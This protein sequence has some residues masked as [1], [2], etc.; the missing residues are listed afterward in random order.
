VFTKLT[1]KIIPAHKLALPPYLRD[2]SSYLNETEY[3]EFNTK[4][5]EQRTRDITNNFFELYNQQKGKCDFFNQPLN[6]KSVNE[7]KKF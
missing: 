1:T 6:L 5:V 7:E 3:I 2:R 4:I